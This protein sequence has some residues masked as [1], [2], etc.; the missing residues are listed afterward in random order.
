MQNLS[1]KNVY[2]LLGSVLLFSQLLGF[3]FCGDANCLQGKSDEN[4]ATLLCAILA[5]HAVPASESDDSSD[6]S[7][8][9]YCHLLL[10]LPKI[11]LYATPLNVT[12]LY[13]TDVLHFF[14]TPVYDIYHP[15]L[16]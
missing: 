1:M 10:D 14:V 11:D 2:W 3:I 5:K 13:T 16:A 12:P 7:C 15:P 6:Y 9:C 4:Y 8:D